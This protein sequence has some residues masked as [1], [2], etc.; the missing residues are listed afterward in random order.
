MVNPDVRHA[1]EEER[2]E[3]ANLLGDKVQHGAH[4]G[5][6]DVG[7]EDEDGLAGTE[8]GAGGVEVA[9]AEP[10]G[11]ARGLALVG[12]LA[13]GG[14]E[15]QVE[16]PSEELV[17][18][19]AQ[20]LPD[21]RVVK[22]LLEANAGEQGL[23]GRL[24]GGGGDKGHV[25]LYVAVVEVVAVVGELPREEGHQ[26]EAV[27]G[28]AGDVVDLVV[29]GEGA[30]AALVAQ[31]PDAGAD[32]ALDEAVDHPGGDA[33]VRVGDG[34]DEGEGSP[35][36]GGHHGQVAED[37]VVRGDQRRLEAMGGNSILDGLDV[38]ENGF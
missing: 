2:V 27:Q 15:E 22:E 18:D 6:A 7:E 14:V 25:L 31:D 26:E 29:Q 12:A 1:V 3:A 8:H 19:E 34:G 37:V 16:L 9:D 17:A 35:D 24:G 36:E 13:G 28:P 38:R 23:A 10:L 32:E 30:V 20:H 5:Q 33:E 4:D 21:G 11:E